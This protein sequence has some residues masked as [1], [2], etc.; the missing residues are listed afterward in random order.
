MTALLVVLLPLCG[1]LLAWVAS[2]WGRQRPRQV[3]LL[4]LVLWLGLL[5]VIGVDA[6][7]GTG[8]WSLAC[9]VPWI[10]WLGA[11]LHLVIDGLSL[12]ML[13]LTALL[14]AVG[15]AISQRDAGDRPGAFYFCYMATLGGLAAVFAAAD[16]L[17]FFVAYEAMLAPMFVLIA[18]WGDADQERTGA[19]TRFLVFTQAGGL[20]LLA[21]ILGLVLSGDQFTLDYPALLG[22]SIPAAAGTALLVCL[23]LAFAV[24]LPLVPLH[25]WQPGAYAAVPAS[26]GIV[27]AGVMAKTGGYGVLRLV[28]PL[29]P[30]TAQAWAGWIM[31]WAAGSIVFG[32]VVAFSCH[33]L[34][35]FIAYSGISHLGFVVLGAFAGNEWAYRGA[36]VQMVCHGLTA[37]GL[38]ILAAWLEEHAGTRDLR[39]LGGLRQ[40]A[41]RTGAFGLVVFMAV[42]GLPGLG[43][44]VG[45]FLVL[46]GVYQVA[47]WLAAIA[48]LGP[49]LAAAYALRL[50][51]Q[52]FFGPP[53]AR[54]QVPD[55]HG[56]AGAAALV[57]VL[58]LLWVG[59]YPQPLL[60]LVDRGRS[61]LAAPAPARR[62]AGPRGHGG[63]G[64][65]HA[66]AMPDHPAAG[67]A[68]GA[69]PHHPGA[70]AP[71][72]AMPQH[73]AA[74]VPAGDGA[75]QGGDR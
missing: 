61:V 35:R 31:A 62:P 17:V 34:R 58:S 28:I 13:G 14:G 45:E 66:G 33:D 52:V 6:G 54:A 25:G 27:L 15:V 21:A 69:M 72:A 12:V 39:L 60:R 5:A 26:V 48:C 46:L 43:S 44:F 74:T 71:A 55:L 18:A 38:F 63:A 68:A 56:W 41:P 10:P 11:S 59:W 29:L 8:R 64:L 7:S 40:L 3:S 30:E 16:L 9:Q 24:K 37:A 1:G 70:E 49:V 51:Q 22:R 75:E 42:V 4:F 2:C 65:P 23:V 50:L 47:P 53:S 57:L 36:V 73:P 32:A 67:S 19:A 20:L